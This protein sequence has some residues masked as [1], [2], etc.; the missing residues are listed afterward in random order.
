MSGAARARARARAPRNQE[1]E[2][3]P[4]GSNTI[5]G[6][7]PEARTPRAPSENPKELE[8]DE[9]RPEEG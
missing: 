6:D 4:S 5:P 2:G 7:E 1:I 3:E 9:D 8:P